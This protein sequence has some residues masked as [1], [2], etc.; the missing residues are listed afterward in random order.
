MVGPSLA[1]QQWQKRENARVRR[2]AKRERREL[3][4]TPPQTTDNMSG[5]GAH[6]L[7]RVIESR[8]THCVVDDVESLGVGKPSHVAVDRLGLVINRC[9]TESPGNRRLVLGDGR[10]NP[11]PKAWAI[12][13]TM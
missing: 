3:M 8:S 11:R 13:T 4:N 6:R 7:E 12:C 1:R 2:P 10:E 9:C 5:V